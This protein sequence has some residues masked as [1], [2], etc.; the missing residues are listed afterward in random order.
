MSTGI[1]KRKIFLI[2]SLLLVVIIIA[3]STYVFAFNG[4]IFGWQFKDNEGSERKNG[5]SPIDYNPP[6]QEQIDAGNDA[7]NQTI[8]ENEGETSDPSD[9]LEVTITAAN[10]NTP[11]FQIRT[12]VSQLLTSGSCQLTMTKDT[13]TIFRTVNIQAAS[14]S[15][16]CQG[17]DIPLTDLSAGIWNV[18]ISVTSGT[19]SG[20]AE[21]TVEIK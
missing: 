2:L 5:N 20:V 12:L 7:K 10:Q 6:T 1:G 14:S 15:S 4:S 9:G 17:F 11:N 16:T 13:Q 19:Q 3:L 8:K 21:R 18:K